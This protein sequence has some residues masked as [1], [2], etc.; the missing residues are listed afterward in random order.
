MKHFRKMRPDLLTPEQ[1]K[2][3]RERPLV[4]RIGNIL[5]TP[6]MAFRKLLLRS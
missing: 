4:V 2:K 3:S 6:Y 1:I 5:I